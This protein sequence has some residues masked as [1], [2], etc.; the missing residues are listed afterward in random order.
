MLR[1]LLFLATNVAVMVVLSIAVKVLGLE[2]ALDS[3]AGAGES[4]SAP[5]AESEWQKVADASD[6]PPGSSRVV[7]YRGD[8]VAIFNM[9]GQLHAVSNRCP[10]AN[11]SLSEGVM[12]DGSVVCPSHRSRFDLATGQPLEGPAARPL[13][14]YSV[15]LEQNGV[16]LG[17][18]T[19]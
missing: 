7:Y 3:L 1:I 5:A 8:Q 13:R 6:I 9:G 15:R 12:E 2:E 19:G 16:L 11:G 4:G 10:H 18:S 14:I 17:P